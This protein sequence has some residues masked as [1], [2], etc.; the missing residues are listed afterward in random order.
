MI[1][2]WIVKSLTWHRGHHWVRFMSRTSSFLWSNRGDKKI[3]FYFRLFRQ[4]ASL[5]Y[6]K[7]VTISF[8]C[9]DLHESDFDYSRLSGTDRWAG[10]LHSHSFQTASNS[11]PTF[12]PKLKNKTAV[13]WVV[14]GVAH[15]SSLFFWTT[16]RPTQG[17]INLIISTTYFFFVEARFQVRG[18]SRIWHET[19]TSLT[20]LMMWSE[21]KSPGGQ[22]TILTKGRECRVEHFLFEKK[23]KRK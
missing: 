15:F 19:K 2:K 14:Y 5:E 17:N 1:K 22:C 18:F 21:M 9:S 8:G 13:C 7:E 11:A 10:D 6:G 20:T 16:P 23:K 3:V 4:T 12:N